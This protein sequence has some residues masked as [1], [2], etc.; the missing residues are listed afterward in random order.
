VLTRVF[1]AERGANHVQ[2]GAQPQRARTLPETRP[3][4]RGWTSPSSRH[5]EIGKLAQE[6]VMEPKALTY[7]LTSSSSVGT[8]PHSGPSRS[9]VRSVALAPP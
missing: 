2:L 5:P 1:A 4:P 7:P 6:G 8:P 9:T 3:S